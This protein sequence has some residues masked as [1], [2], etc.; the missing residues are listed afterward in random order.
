MTAARG[1]IHE[2]FHSRAFAATGGVREERLEESTVADSV[3]N[4]TCTKGQYSGLKG[5]ESG[6]STNASYLE[7]EVKR[8]EGEQ[9]CMS[10]RKA[11]E[12]EGEQDDEW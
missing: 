2:E 4:R 10:Y 5:E 12:G 1:I 8:A 9:R 11:S 6:A 7:R 3:L